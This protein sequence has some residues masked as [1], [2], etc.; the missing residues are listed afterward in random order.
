MLLYAPR[1]LVEEKLMLASMHKA[2][3]VHVKL[4]SKQIVARP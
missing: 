1:D 4:G 2:Y 3:F